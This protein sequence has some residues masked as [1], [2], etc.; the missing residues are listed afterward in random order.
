MKSIWF[1]LVLFLSFSQVV[2]AQGAKFST[3]HG[4]PY[5]QA[6][7]LLIQAG[8]RVLPNTRI[9]ES[10]MF[11]QSVHAS[12]FEEVLDCISMERDQC[13]FV[14]SKGNSWIVVTTKDKT[15][16]VETIKQMKK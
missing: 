5:A 7:P 6:R 11:A 3:Y 10:S 13:Q 1:A 15:F 9:Q 2:L 16:T 4:K 14:L 8:W 12:Q